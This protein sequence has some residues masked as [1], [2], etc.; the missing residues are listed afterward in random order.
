MQMRE[1]STREGG[2]YSHP[3][4]LPSEPQFPEK[5]DGIFDMP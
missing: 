5:T 3:P 1:P 4:I 2:N